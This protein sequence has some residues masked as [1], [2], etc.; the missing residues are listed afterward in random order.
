MIELSTSV[1]L[2]G[3]WRDF[4]SRKRVKHANL[5][6]DRSPYRYIF[7]VASLMQAQQNMQS[8]L[9]LEV[10]YMA[11]SHSLCLF[12]KFPLCSSLGASPLS[13]GTRGSG[14]ETTCVP[15]L[16]CC[17]GPPQLSDGDMET[18]RKYTGGK[19]DPLILHFLTYAARAR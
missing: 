2:K 3:G 6:Q 5:Y 12:K 17:A 15:S 13:S 16:H 8:F 19:D 11:S 18:V 1:N 7:S 10:E 4:T 14:T 9:C